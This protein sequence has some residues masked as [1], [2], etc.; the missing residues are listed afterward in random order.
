MK[1][2]TV[3]KFS[4]GALSEK[5]A[6]SLVV[7]ELIRKKKIA[8]RKDISNETGINIVS[9]SNYVKDFMEENLLVEEGIDVSTGGRKPELI[10]LNAKENY[11]LGVDTGETMWRYS[12]VDI[13]LKKICGVKKQV[14][15]FK[16]K[17]ASAV[18]EDIT[19]QMA[20]EAGI[21]LQSVRAV[22]IAVSDDTR[23]AGLESLEKRFGN[24]F[25]ICDHATCAAFGE[26]YLNDKCGVENLLY[27]YSDLGAALVLKGENLKQVDG[28]D[29][30]YLRSWGKYF[31]IDE[32]AR[33]E[34]A[35]GVGTRMVEITGAD[36]RMIT[37]STV[38]EAA[39]QN[40]EAALNI[41]GGV[42]MN[43]GFR[44]SYLINLFSPEVVLIN[45][46]IEAAGDLLLEPIKKAVKKFALKS[47]LGKI[48]ITPGILGNDAV[49]LGAASLA[50]REI[51]LKA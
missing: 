5:E 29:L 35:R 20:G 8:S 46:G 26:K 32:M 11:A 15:E 51:F 50:V 30:K 45:G 44:I 13:G 36:T 47:R 34:I 10:E 40:D 21:K 38:I 17:D 3:H 24:N 37:K 6:K 33:R 2:K 14:S 31:S 7:L 25:Y 42:G 22:G 9:V 28:E 12:L 16:D 39:R 18:I 19:N 49:S 4:L 27:I 43:L 1:I 23:A 48:D 41:L